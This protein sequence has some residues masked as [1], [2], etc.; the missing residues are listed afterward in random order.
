MRTAVGRIGASGGLVPSPAQAGP[1]VGADPALTR[2][3]QDPENPAKDR[4]KFLRLA[5]R[6]LVH[7]KNS[8]LL[9]A[10]RGYA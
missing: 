6:S 1:G 4:T 10:A 8:F 3:L 9:P 5:S 2:H 7:V